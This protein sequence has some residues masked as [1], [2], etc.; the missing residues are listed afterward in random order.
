MPVMAHHFD[1]QRRQAAR[2]RR[3][4]GQPRH[5]R[6]RREEGRLA[7]AD[8]AGHPRRRPP[9]A[10]PSSWTPS[11]TLID[12]ARD[13]QAHRRRPRRRQHLAHQPGR[14]RHDRLGAAA[15]G[16]PGHDRRHRLDRL[17]GRASAASARMIGAEKVM[18][19]TSTYDHRDHPG[20]RVRALPA[21]RSR[22]TCRASTASTRTSSPS[23]GATL[24]PPLAPP[25]PPLAAAARGRAPRRRRA[26]GATTEELLQAVQA[27]HLAAQGPPH[28]RPPRRAARPAR[29][30]ARG[31]P[32]ARPRHR[33]A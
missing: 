27:A 24:G 9:V 3:R 29:H 23:L 33:A 11:T 17:P 6:R 5:R 16:R 18:T 25:Q 30:R 22:P 20:R 12:K 8:G 32:G 7:H 31:R 26:R 4:A 10:S 28:A 1:E 2:A 14:H 21:G 13:E 19:M 15:D